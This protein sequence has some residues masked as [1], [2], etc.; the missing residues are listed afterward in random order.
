MSAITGGPGTLC[1]DP[2][3]GTL[4]QEGLSVFSRHVDAVVVSLSWH[5]TMVIEQG[6]WEHRRTATKPHGDNVRNLRTVH[7][8]EPDIVGGA[9]NRR[10]GASIPQ[11]NS[12]EVMT[13]HTSFEYEQFESHRHRFSAKGDS[14]ADVRWPEYTPEPDQRICERL[15]TY[16][17][18]F[19]VDADGDGEFTTELDEATW[20]TLKV[21]RRYR[22]KVGGF[23]DKVKQVTP[24]A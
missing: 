2:R 14:P 24:V 15:E 23:S 13:K 3:R 8:V 19:R 20:R 4:H 1:R 10:A 5:R 21:G 6:H 9:D 18:T 17:V 7:D 16:S 11:A 22:L 12:Y